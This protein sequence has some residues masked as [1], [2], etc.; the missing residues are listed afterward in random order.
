MT[1]LPTR[2][3]IKKLKKLSFCLINEALC[4]EGI[5]GNGGIAPLHGGEWSASHPDHLPL[6]KFPP[7]SIGEEAEWAPELVWM[8]WR[9]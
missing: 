8:L 3:N 4:H 7:I 6:G 5:R 9:R 2:K 1:G